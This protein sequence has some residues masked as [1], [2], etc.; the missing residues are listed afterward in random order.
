[1]LTVTY[2]N[3]SISQQTPYIV[4]RL[5]KS[6]VNYKVRAF[7]IRFCCIVRDKFYIFICNADILHRQVV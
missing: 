1:M 3:A 4:E 5:C 6:D 7:N 2:Q